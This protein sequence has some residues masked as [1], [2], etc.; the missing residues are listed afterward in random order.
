MADIAVVF[1]WTPADM[2]GM[3]ISEL[4]RWRDKAAARWN[5]ED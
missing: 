4:T 2:A 5:P 3:S 1:G